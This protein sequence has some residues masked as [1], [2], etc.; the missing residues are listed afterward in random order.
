MQFFINLPH[1]LISKGS[2]NENAPEGKYFFKPY[3]YL[4]LLTIQNKEI[5]KNKKDL[6]Y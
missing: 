4:K 3:F 2:T 5:G 6:L 1:T